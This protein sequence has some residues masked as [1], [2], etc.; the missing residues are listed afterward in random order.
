VALPAVEGARAAPL[1]PLADGWS[2]RSLYRPIESQLGSRGG[3]LRLGVIG[4]CIALF[5]IMCNKWNKW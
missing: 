2:W 5:I 4:M 3:L 1:P